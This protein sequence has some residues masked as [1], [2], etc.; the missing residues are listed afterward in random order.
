MLNNRSLST[1]QNNCDYTFSH[2][3]AA[4]Q[5]SFINAHCIENNHELPYLYFS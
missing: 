3:R 5:L 2:N 4:L 1:G